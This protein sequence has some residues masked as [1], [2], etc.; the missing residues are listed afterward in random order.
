MAMVNFPE[1]Q[2]KIQEEI[3]RVVGKD[4]LPGLED[5]NKMPYTM[6]VELELYRYFTPVGVAGPRNTT[7]DCTYNGYSIPKGTMVRFCNKERPHI[8][9]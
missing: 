9:K 5:R 7:Q 1:V 2:K 3:Q 6:A 4:R 8:C